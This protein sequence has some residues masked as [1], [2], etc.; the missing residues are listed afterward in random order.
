VADADLIV[1]CTPVDMVAEHVAAIRR[2]SARSDH[3]RCRQHQGVDRRRR[4]GRWEG[5]LLSNRF[6]ASFL[7][8]IRWLAARKPECDS[9]TLRS[10]KDGPS[11]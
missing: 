9:P 8:A 4:R 3:H 1:V 7:A 10:F 5:R 2:L 6:T 11:S